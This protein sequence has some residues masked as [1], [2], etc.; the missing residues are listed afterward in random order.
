MDTAQLQLGITG[1]QALRQISDI[2]A[3]LLLLPNSARHT[4]NEINK[5]LN[6]IATTAAAVKGQ[7]ASIATSTASAATSNQQAASTATNY[8]AALRQIQM[9]LS[10]TNALL[11][12]SVNSTNSL[13]FAMSQLPQAHTATATNATAASRAHGELNISMLS[14]LRTA[15]ALL[16]IQFGAAGL[17]ELVVGSVQADITMQRMG[18]TLESVSGSAAAARNSISFLR[19]ESDRI[20]T[21]FVDAAS[22]FSRFSAATSG[23]SINQQQ[24]RQ[25]FSDV[26]ESAQRLHLSG[27]EVARVF[28]AMEQMASKGVVS[29]EELRRQL[30]NVIPGAFNIAARAMG[31]TTEELNKMIKSGSVL[32]ED[33]LPKLAA[34][35]RRTFPLGDAASSTAAEINRVKNAWVDL[36]AQIGEDMRPATNRFMQELSRALRDAKVL[37]GLNL[38]PE[39]AKH[40]TSAMLTAGLAGILPGGRVAADALLSQFGMD[41]DTQARIAQLQM[42]AAAKPE[43]TEAVRERKEDA[44]QLDKLRR[45]QEDW[46]I[47]SLEGVEQQIA[48]AEVT[49]LRAIR[50]IEAMTGLKP[51]TRSGAIGLA[52]EERDRAIVKANWDAVA[53]EDERIRKAQQDSADENQ[54]TLQRLGE[55]RRKQQEAFAKLSGGTGGTRREEEIARENERYREQTVILHQEAEATENL[56][57]VMRVWAEVEASHARRLDDINEKHARRFIGE[58]SVIQLLERRKQIE[59]ELLD[60]QQEDPEGADKARRLQEQLRSINQGITGQFRTGRV[61]SGEGLAFG[62]REVVDGWGEQAER[63]R[64]IGTT[65]ANSMESAFTG[66]FTSTMLQQKDLAS[67]FTEMTNSIVADIVRIT[68]QEQVSKP[69]AGM[70]GQG[71]GAIFGAFSGSSAG[72]TLPAVGTY[73]TAA[74]LAHAGGVIGVDTGTRSVSMA[75]FSRSQRWHSGGSNI[76]GD[77]QAVIARRGEVMFTP[78]QLK[79]LTSAI[80]GALPR[81]EKGGTEIFNVVDEEM[82]DRRLAANPNAVLN[83]IGAHKN[84][85]RRLLK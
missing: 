75:D 68:I 27:P 24:T 33:L 9:Q 41:T 76:V 67:A 69:L 31:V 48:R 26:A 57:D 5:S 28:L 61:S 55:E 32:S 45:M 56:S 79:A 7:M 64:N 10:Q 83:V 2:E 22:A 39:E 85:I 12:A 44:E 51:S 77:E 25:I 58:G 15:G 52:D 35:M 1:E 19:V 37:F 40:E 21:V 14:V 62:F 50:T 74:G 71:I 23:T 17:R 34:E 81:S 29:M 63:M 65:T 8:S 30:G 72:T 73:G 42:R 49:R 82:V 47:S 53:E 80:A 20:G 54:K 16:G 36:K 78:E 11:N 4:A 46:W 60:I 6:A 84:T 18:M 38:K 43:R 59:R 13:N 70:L 66:F 3:A